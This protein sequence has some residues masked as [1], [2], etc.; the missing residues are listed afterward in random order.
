M[1]QL[2]TSLSGGLI[3]VRDH[4]GSNVV[5]FIHQSVNDS[6]L[7]GGFEWL[8]LDS[9]A[10]VVG[11]GHHRLARSCVNYLKLGEVQE[12][13]L[14]SSSRSQG[15]RQNPPFLE[16]AIQSWF[17]HAQT[18][19]SKGITQNDLIQRFD[20][21][22]AHY[23]HHWIDMFQAI[24]ESRLNPRRP[25]LLST[26]LHISAA[27]NLQSIV[28]ELVAFRPLLEEKDSQGNTALHFAARFGYDNVVS[29]LLDAEANLQA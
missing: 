1:E 4:H 19:E 20:W 14:L 23:F 6:L 10:D 29:I 11:Q 2:I 7:K 27:L 24:D 9:R 3:E 15:T 21:P 18:A 26:L 8:G 12:I 28:Q 16:Y 17:L 22:D 25:Q 5:Q 13:K